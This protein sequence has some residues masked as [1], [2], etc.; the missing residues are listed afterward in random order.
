M[1]TSIYEIDEPIYG[2]GVLIYGM[3]TS[4]YWM[5]TSLYEIDEPIYG[6]H[7]PIYGIDTLIYGIVIS[8]FLPV[9]QG[10]A[11]SPAQVVALHKVSSLPRW[12]PL[13]PVESL[14]SRDPRNNR[15]ETE[16]PR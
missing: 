14:T 6:M 4:I 7:T 5:G 3:D 10:G 11:P 12:P 13:G 1:D 9:G 8:H 15:V 2:M 16:R